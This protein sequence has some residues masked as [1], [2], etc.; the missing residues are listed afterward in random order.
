MVIVKVVKF[1]RIVVWMFILIF[2]MKLFLGIIII[3]S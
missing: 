3:V 2:F 1:N